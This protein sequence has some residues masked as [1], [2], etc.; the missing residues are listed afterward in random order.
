[1][2]SIFAMTG[3]TRDA[4]LTMTLI[5]GA[6]AHATF[7]EPADQRG[8]F[9]LELIRGLPEVR[10]DVPSGGRCH[11]YELRVGIPSYLK[12]E[13]EVLEELRP[14]GLSSAPQVV[15]CV[16]LGADAPHAVLVLRYRDCPGEH[17]VPA[18]LHK[19]YGARL[20]MGTMAA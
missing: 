9:M 16:T 3:T 11:E 15:R 10:L 2:G 18:S 13:S 5:D 6:I 8:K 14:L 4:D 7:S 17:L 12:R 20:M 1:M 19:C